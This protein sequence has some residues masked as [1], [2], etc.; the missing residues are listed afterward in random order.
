MA[1]PGTPRLLRAIND[2]AVLELL[3]ADGPLSRP[4]LGDLTGLSRPTMSQVLSRLTAAG[5]VRP[6]GSSPGR[7]GPNAVLYE[8]EPRAAHVAGL[9]VTPRRIRAAVA[10]LT[11]RIVGRHELPT[12]GRARRGHRGSGRPMRSTPPAG[13]RAS[14]A[15]CYAGRWSAHRAPSTPARNGSAMHDTYR[16]GT[17]PA[18]STGS[19][20]RSAMPVDF[21]NDVNL[22]AV[23]ELTPG[24]RPGQRELRPAVGR[25]RR[26]CGDRHRRTPPPG[27]HRWSR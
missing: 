4:A 15:P 2:R 19:A 22:A 18:C 25:G 12:P 17:M 10:D 9:D 20:T 24:R 1:E 11:G 26:R 7:R 23:A 27:V 13:T 21:D 14:T 6:S 5:L 3:L 16:A 8:I